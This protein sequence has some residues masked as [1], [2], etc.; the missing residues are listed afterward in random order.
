MKRIKIINGTFGHRPAGSKRLDP[1]GVNDP[2]FE[3]DDDKAERLVSLGVAEYA[4]AAPKEKPSPAAKDKRAN[5]VATRSRGGKPGKASVSPPK[6]K[7]GAQSAA[8]APEKPA[9]D[10]DT[11]ID[12]L[13]ALMR[14]HGLPYRVGMTKAE[15]AAALDEIFSDAGNGAEESPAGD[16]GEAPPNIG[17][18]GPVT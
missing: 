6:T 11:K 5:A 9:Y 3:I 16:D 2:P 13:R 17:G 14:E 1:K 7:P 12:E 4:D 10:A 8:D 18:E 15:M